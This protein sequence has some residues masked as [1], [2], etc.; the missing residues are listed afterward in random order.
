[1][2][3]EWEQWRLGQPR[4]TWTKNNFINC[5][6]I[7]KITR[8]KAFCVQQD[9]IYLKTK[10]LGT[11]ASTTPKNKRAKNKRVN[12]N[13]L[14]L[15]EIEHGKLKFYSIWKVAKVVFMAYL[16]LRNKFKLWISPPVYT[17]CHKFVDEL[18][19]RLEKRVGG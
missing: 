8:N 4:D 14:P 17:K 7:L 19:S 18:K 13:L 15:W 1:M 12:V 11:K 3:R 6:K 5:A 2:R 16:T 9:H 10:E